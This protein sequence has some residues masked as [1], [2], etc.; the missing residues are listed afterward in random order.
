MSDGFLRRRWGLRLILIRSRL[1]LMVRCQ[2]YALL[3]SGLLG[4]V[5][6]LACRIVVRATV[7]R[8]G[9]RSDFVY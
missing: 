3:V 7:L 5:R 1:V 9:L 2:I 6:T 4:M 8:V